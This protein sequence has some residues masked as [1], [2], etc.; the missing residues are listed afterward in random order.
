[1]P[2]KRGRDGELYEEPTGVVK[3]REEESGGE[4]ATKPLRSEPEDSLFGPGKSR[5]SEA[6]DAN[7]DAPT[8]PLRRGRGEETRIISPAKRAAQE[9][10]ASA[11][12]PMNDP[13]VGW[14]V[15]V[16]GPGKGRVLTLGNGM[17]AIG[18]SETSRIRVDFGDDSISR[19]NHA[20]IAYE[21]RQRSFLLNHGEGANLTYLNGEVVMEA[22]PI[23]PGAEIQIGDT[24]L[25]FQSFCSKDFDWPDVDD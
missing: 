4:P 24:T 18:R 2:I 3:G 11:K 10:A 5:R 14:L 19:S 21:P 13:P 25:R 7:W 12:D 16:R 23:A 1:M 6:G 8:T 9:D 15:I 20:R 17:N 22:K